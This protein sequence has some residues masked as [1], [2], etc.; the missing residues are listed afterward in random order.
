MARRKLPE[1]V[2]QESF[3]MTPMIDI[4]FQLLI[5]FMLVMD[6]SKAQ[7]EILVVPYASKAIKEKFEDPTLM[8]INVMKDGAIK[9]QGK[10]FWKAGQEDDNKRLEDLFIS[11][12]QDPKYQEVKGREDW[13]RYAILVRAD[14]STAFEHVQKILMMAA[15]HGGITR[16]QLGAKKEGN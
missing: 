1:E 16:I 12:K 14:R 6:M 11:R 8:V 2:P 15:L 5:F 10:V 9:I 3:N 13:V 7:L 4:V